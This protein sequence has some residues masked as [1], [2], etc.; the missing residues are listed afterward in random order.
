MNPLREAFKYII[1]GMTAGML[2]SCASIGNPSGG[3]RDEAPPRPLYSRP[4]S[5]STGVTPQKIDIIFDELVNVK[6]A[7]SKVIVSPPG[8]SPARI[9]SSGRRVT[10]SFT[11][12]LLP[13]TTYTVDFGDAIEDNNEANKLNSFTY[14]FS[15]GENIDTL[16]ISGMV[17]DA[18]TLEPQQGML[19]GVHT[20]EADSAFRTLPFERMARTDDRGR[21]S[22][23]GLPSGN[24]RIFALG[25]LNNDYRWDN[26]EEII[27]FGE[28]SVSPYAEN[29]MVMD[30]LYDMRTALP[31]T[32]LELPGVRYLPDDVLLN[33]FLT[34][35]KQQYV[36]KY[37]RS[38]SLRLSLIFNA[39]N[40]NLPQLRIISPSGQ[41]GDW[42]QTEHSRFNDTVTYWIK[43]PVLMSSDSISVAFDYM[44]ASRPYKE[45]LKTD[46]LHFISKPVFV[47]KSKV[48]KKEKEPIR[49]MP[50]TVYGNSSH[51][52][53][54]PLYLEFGEPPAYI[55][56]TAFYLEEKVD[57]L[58]KVVPRSWRMERADTLNPRRYMINY[59]W[60]PGS[61]Y[62][63]RNDSLAAYGYSGLHV[64]KNMTGL[65]VR[66][67]DDYAAVTFLL[68][69][70]PDSVP[71]MVEL[72]QADRPVRSLVVKNGR[73]TFEYVLPG[74]YYARLY[75]DSNGNGEYDTGDYYMLRQP[76]ATFYYPKRIR[77]KK[78]W[79]VELPWDINALNIDL[80]KPMEIR[81]NR[82]SDSRKRKENAD[83]EEEE[84]D[85]FD[86]TA[87]PFDPN[88]KKRRK[89]E[90]ERAGY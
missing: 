26:P 85:Y 30:T 56:S 90:R 6:D 79:D 31:D 34:D 82:P 33:A 65:V 52:F 60:T 28:T 76:E 20:S 49:F 88:D 15:T 9:S 45:E 70:L 11:D 12:S 48:K 14:T 63:L 4:P 75:I 16:R 13:N 77:L 17:L 37:E 10:V 2:Y 46:T 27:A 66:K 40:R 80:Q 35:F 74:D 69:G 25:D 24:Y 57:T 29:V 83:P 87:N 42:Y 55:D 36:V 47:K 3:P 50:L 39:K 23:R 89:R 18:R 22:I 21:F 86:P 8:K 59:S 7:F 67:L 61:E 71:A 72:L 1:I 58:W 68:S 5:G 78:Y 73:V 54:S 84:D 44:V 32:V 53:F 19:V 51:D 62:R 43:D 38:D 64:N 81:K 41:K